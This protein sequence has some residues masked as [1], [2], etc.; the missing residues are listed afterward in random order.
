[1]LTKEE[2]YRFY[3][4]LMERENNF[5]TEQI[6]KIYLHNSVSAAKGWISSTYF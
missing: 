6:I 3:L 2:L 4:V 1:M 5:H